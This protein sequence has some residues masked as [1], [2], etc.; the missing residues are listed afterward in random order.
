MNRL[1]KDIASIDTEAA[2]SE[3]SYHVPLTPRSLAVLCKLSAVGDRCARRCRL[4]H[5]L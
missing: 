5:A 1:S 3:L 2:E 4:L